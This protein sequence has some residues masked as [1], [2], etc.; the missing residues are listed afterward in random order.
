MS[1]KYHSI[2]AMRTSFFRGFFKILSV[3][4]LFTILVFSVTF[5]QEPILPI[6]A[7]IELNQSKVALGKRLFHEV[8]LSVDD[9]LSCAS[10]HDLLR[11]GV[12]RLKASIGVKG[13]VGEMNA[14]TVYNSG[15]NFVQFWDG[16]AK[17]L[18]D[19]IEGP[20]NNPG[21]MGSNWPLIVRKLAQDSTYVRDF[22]KDYKEG[23]TQG[24]IKDAIATFERSLITPNSRFDQYLNGDPNAITASEKEGYR[25]FKDYGCVSCHQGKNVGGNMYQKLGVFRPFFNAKGGP[26]EYM[27]PHDYGRFNVT[28]REKDRYVF[29]VPSLRN[30]AITAPYL[31]DGILNTLEEVVAVMGEYQL[32]RNLSPKDIELIVQFLKTLTGQYQGELLR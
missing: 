26:H 25:L 2:F 4:A 12:D 16:R 22:K 17:T 20:V 1:L 19:Q 29:R 3:T 18:E 9:T 30:V 21:E 31:H 23:I 6:P 10:C 14:P 28:Q 15:F 27:K 13:Q 7:S 24:S 32:G 8:K 11:G 5:A